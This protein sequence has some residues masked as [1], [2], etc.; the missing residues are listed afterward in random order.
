MKPMREKFK[1]TVRPLPRDRFGGKGPNDMARKKYS[2]TG[3]QL[4]YWQ[5]Y[6]TVSYYVLTQFSLKE[7]II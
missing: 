5:Y 3:S 1:P 2:L 7:A 4:L 6:F